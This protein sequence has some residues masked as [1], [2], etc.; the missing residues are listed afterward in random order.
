MFSR[1][2]LADVR[3]SGL[4]F[5]LMEAVHGRL[6]YLLNE[7][8]LS[9]N[10]QRVARRLAT[11]PHGVLRKSAAPI[12][13]PMVNGG[14][15]T[16]NAI[17]LELA[18]KGLLREEV[19]GSE[20]WLIFDHAAL[21]LTPEEASACVSALNQLQTIGAPHSPE[22]IASLKEFFMSEPPIFLALSVT[23]HDVFTEL[24]SRSD[25]GRLTFL[26]FP[27]RSHVPQSLH[28]HYD[29]V[30]KKWITFLIKGNGSLRSTT[31]FRVATVEFAEIYTSGMSSAG[32]RINFIRM[33]ARSTREG[34]IIFAPASTSLYALYRARAT[35]VWA[36]ASPLWVLEKQQYLMIWLERV[37]WPLLLVA[38]ALIAVRLLGSLV[39]GLVAA[40]AI[41]LLREW[42]ASAIGT[43]TWAR[44][45][46]FQS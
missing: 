29:E 19:I 43:K 13:A 38:I 22:G 9:P 46:L 25:H 32:A 10:A 36:S 7:R 12:V 21:G 11:E 2:T 31:R 24:Q 42:V 14:D 30:L 8:A 33:D 41:G 3:L 27:S 44:R 35:E 4:S 45:E 37:I 28:A 6:D 1:E 26:V 20:V 34:L 39:G 17:L 15:D 23:S 16:A 18:T 5:A 40:L